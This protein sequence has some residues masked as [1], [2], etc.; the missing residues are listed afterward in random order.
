MTKR[1][2]NQ[3]QTDGEEADYRSV[4]VTGE[5]HVRVD[6]KNSLGIPIG[7]PDAELTIAISCSPDQVGPGL[8]GPAMPH[9]HLACSRQRPAPVLGNYEL[10][11]AVA[12]GVV[13]QE[14]PGLV[15]PAECGAGRPGAVDHRSIGLCQRAY[16][17]G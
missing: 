15:R 4:S 1:G 10:G 11:Q 9:Q 13:S 5:E 17:T 6:S 16:P 8:H 12:S 7:I 2:Y 14:Q 3:N